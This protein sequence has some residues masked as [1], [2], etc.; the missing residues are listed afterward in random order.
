MLENFQRAIPL[1]L[2]HEGKFVNDPHDPGGAT[3]LGVTI[4]TAKAI[5]L[6]VDGDGDTDIIDI[7]LLKPADAAKVYK[8]FYWDAV[9]GDL[10]PSGVDYTVFDFAV[11]SGVSRAAKVLQASLGAYPD[12]HVGPKTLG[13]V[14]LYPAKEIIRRVNEDRMAFLK[15]LPTFSRYGR[16]WSTRVKAV[17]DTSLQWAK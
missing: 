16:G 7:K 15:S 13:A 10:L 9:C 5:G 17:W 4:G 11:N 1:V 8:R 14:G 2:A 12:G 6:D 3:N